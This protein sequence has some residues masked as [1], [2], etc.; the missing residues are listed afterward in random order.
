MKL[1]DKVKLSRP[2]EGEKD[3]IFIVVNINDSTDRILIECINSSMLI[4]P[5]ELVSVNDVELI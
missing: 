3:L 4:N 1:H 5:V 2:S